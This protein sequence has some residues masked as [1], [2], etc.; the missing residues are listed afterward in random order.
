[1]DWCG[2]LNL[3]CISSVAFPRHNPESE[4][5]LSPNSVQGDPIMSQNS[6]LVAEFSLLLVK[7]DFSPRAV[8]AE[9]KA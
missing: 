4:L 8:E 2:R 5:S 9:T 7:W 6:T 3:I 1:M